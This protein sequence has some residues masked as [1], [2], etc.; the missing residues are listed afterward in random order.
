M[1]KVL[2]MLLMVAIGVG[3]GLTISGRLSSVN[4]KS[5]PGTGFAA[6]PGSLGS[7]DLTGAY[8]V[9]KNWPQD[10]STLPGNEKWTYGAGESVF[11]E[12][13][14]RIYMLFRG[15]LPKMA[16]PKAVLLPQL[17]PSLTFPVAGFWR[18]AT[19]A[20]L[21][22]TGGT[23]NN[24]SE[25]LTSW[26]G[27]APDLGI[28]GPPY[29]QLGV[30]AKWENCVVVVDGN[31]K[32]IETWKQWDKLFRRPHSIYISPYDPEKNVWIVDDNMQVIYKFTHD[33]S[34][35]LQTI[36]TPEVA[37]AD[38]THFNRPTYLDWLPDGT[39]FVSDGYTGTR[40]AKFNKDGKFLM[41]WGTLG[42]PPRG[43][44]DT[45][46]SLLQQR[47]WRGG[48][49]GDPSRLCERSK[50]SPH[51]GVRRKRQVLIRMED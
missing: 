45:R 35:L 2:L 12:S 50:Q 47:A 42:G 8:D 43:P 40:V 34:K 1:R 36:G 11:A 41:Q 44:I 3:I 24:V 16:P 37:G 5:K 7:E 10:V 38:A 39:F 30:D 33:G 20:S 23:D 21:P 17:G 46:P 25:W 51:S 32:I 4:A 9:V 18:D 19:V 26:E 49:S 13:P 48:R 6:V 15:E 22:G 31:G 28:K 14:N 27:K 29:R